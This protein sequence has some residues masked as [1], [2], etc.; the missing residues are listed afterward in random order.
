M[1][2]D[3][4][5]D[6]LPNGWLSRDEAELLWS[7]VNKTSGIILEV[8]CYEG[9]STVLLAST[10]RRVV[11]VDPFEG[12]SDHDP[13][14]MNTYNAWLHN[15]YDGRRL[16]N[17]MLYGSRI[18]T[19]EPQPMGFCYLDGDH[20]YKGTYDQIMKA[21]ACQPQAIAIHDVNDNGGGVEVK[22]AALELLGPWTE[23]VERLAVWEG[24]R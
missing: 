23:R 15:V 5:Y 3:E 10:Y 7:A 4:L 21:L 24:L 2:F 20:S 11:C 19:W 13:S 18:E 6:S 1:T 8:G 22:R 16:Y 17:V 9:R 12:F 14:G